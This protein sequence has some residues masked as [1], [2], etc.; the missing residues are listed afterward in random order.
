MGLFSG[1]KSNWKKSEAAVIIQNLLEIQQKA[2]LFDRDPAKVA[3]SL[4]A[5]VWEAMP[6]VFD[7][8][9]GQRPHKISVAAIALATEVKTGIYNNYK[10][11]LLIALGTLLDEVK[12]NG[13]LYP[14]NRVDDSLL[15]SS[16]GIFYDE[17]NNDMA[18]IATDK[19]NGTVNF[20]Y[21]SYDEWYSVFKKAT[22]TVNNGLSEV[23]GLHLVDLMDQE[24]LR[25]AFRDK[26]DPEYL[27]EEFGRNF[28]P[29]KMGF[30]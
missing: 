3:N 23:N 2:G 4:I 17:C 14:F 11:S 6:D 7:G 27:G 16:S 10:S 5:N 1:L 15:I 19:P 24:P 26:V 29:F 28:D 25:R 9:F 21:K 30:K 12:T 22:A 18:E 13:Q 8:K 20:N